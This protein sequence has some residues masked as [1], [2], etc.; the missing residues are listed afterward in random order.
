MNSRVALYTDMTSVIV[1]VDPRVFDRDMRVGGLVE[2]GLRVDYSGAALELFG[3]WEVRIDA[4]PIALRT[5]RLG[6]LGFRVLTLRP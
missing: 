4:D 3:G 6:M 2:G 5:E 1:Q